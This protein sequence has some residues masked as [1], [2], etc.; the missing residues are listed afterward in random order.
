MSAVRMLDKVI[1]SMQDRAM[2]G[3]RNLPVAIAA[4]LAVVACS[5]PN[6]VVSAPA[7]HVDTMATGP[8]PLSTSVSASVV[9]TSTPIG[10]N[11]TPTLMSG[12]VTEVRGLATDASVYGLLFLTHAGPVRV[13]D[14]LKI[15][16]RMTGSGGLAVS[17]TGPDGEAGSLTFGPERHGASSYDRPGDEWGTGLRFDQAG[18]WWIHLQRSTGSGDVWLAVDA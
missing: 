3:C 17:Y 11:E 4:L 9:A 6:A 12:G 15:V 1:D 5:G 16:W 8:V 10:C 14:E 7:D 13:G 18:C 2:R